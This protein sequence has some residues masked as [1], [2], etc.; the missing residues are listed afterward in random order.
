MLH[1]TLGKGRFSGLED[2]GGPVS[3]GSTKRVHSGKSEDIH[4][5]GSS[6]RLA[7]RRNRELHIV[8]P[9]P[10]ASDGR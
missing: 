5:E 2:G 4:V 9:Q 7:S 1:R 6:V 3:A 10:E 8:Q